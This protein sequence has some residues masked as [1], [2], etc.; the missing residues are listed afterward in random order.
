MDE[1]SQYH[2]YGAGSD[3]RLEPATGHTPTLV[4][5]RQLI[6]E[7][8]HVPERRKFNPRLY[9]TDARVSH[10]KT[11]QDY[12]QAEA[13]ESHR[14]GVKGASSFEETS[15]VLLVQDIPCILGF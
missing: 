5:E 9:R 13:R 6:Q 11:N 15:R 10:S 12:W 2:Q 3:T 8:S 14:Y 7:A 1:R 4:S